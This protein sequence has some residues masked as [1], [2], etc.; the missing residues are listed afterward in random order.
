MLQRLRHMCR[1]KKTFTGYFLLTQRKQMTPI[2]MQLF[3]N[4]TKKRKIHITI[5]FKKCRQCFLQQILWDQPASKWRHVSI[6]IV[7][8]FFPFFDS[9][10]PF[11]A[12]SSLICLD[13]FLFVHSQCL[14][15]LSK[16]NL[17]TEAKIAMTCWKKP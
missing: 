8:R 11:S 15:T 14:S 16:S 7:V 4:N 13:W 3:L 2:I 17:R 9:T 5:I 6:A 1:L 10:W 12:F